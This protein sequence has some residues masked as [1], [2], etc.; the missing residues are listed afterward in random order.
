MNHIQYQ[1]NDVV[2]SSDKSLLQFGVIHRYLSEEA[3]WSKKIP[4]HT[5]RTAIENSFCIGIYVAGN[6]VGFCR[7]ISDYA[8]F[9]YLA[10]VFV[11]DGHRGKG[12]SKLM[13]KLIMELPWIRE[14]RRFTLA[15]VD[16]HG[17]YGQFGF[18][19]PKF[20]DRLMEITKP[21]M[22]ESLQSNS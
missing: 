15:T 16:A 18:V 8:T 20:P 1:A 12:L 6:Q 21:K 4:G 10:D 22:Y 19:S 14:L 2:V 11:L 3:Y 9:G 5:V 13:M 17:L 7:I